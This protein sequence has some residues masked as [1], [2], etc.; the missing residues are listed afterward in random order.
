MIAAPDIAP[1]VSSA[2]CPGLDSITFETAVMTRAPAPGVVVAGV[3]FALAVTNLL[4]PAAPPPDA[5]PNTCARASHAVTARNTITRLQIPVGLGAVR[6]INLPPEI[7]AIKSSA[8]FFSCRAADD[9]AGDTS[10][11]HMYSRP[12]LT[13]L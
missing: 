12:A 3:E 10:T 11:P 9:P 6:C 13:L 5:K 4:E 8:I 1:R 7:R 2:I